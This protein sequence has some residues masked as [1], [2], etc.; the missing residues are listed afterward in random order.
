MRYMN[1]IGPQVRRLR[2]ARG[3]SQSIFTAKLQILG[4]EISRASLSK[5]EARLNY[6]DDT[7]ML[8]LAEALKVPVQDL[9]PQRQAGN[10]LREFLEKLNR[11]RF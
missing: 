1:N 3:W 9:F 2:N 11:T 8:Y 4:L 7:T 5:I 6:V 10:R